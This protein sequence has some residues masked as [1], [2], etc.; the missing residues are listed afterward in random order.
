MR[1]L[2]SQSFHTRASFTSE[3]T[4]LLVTSQAILS[5]LPAGN[6]SELPRLPTLLSSPGAVGPNSML[7]SLLPWSSEACLCA[8]LL[9]LMLLPKGL[10]SCSP[11]AQCFVPHFPPPDDWLLE[12][13]EKQTQRE[14]RQ[15]R[16]S[17]QQYS[18]S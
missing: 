7:V 9:T 15:D 5:C 10:V 6:L 1:S 3:N 4:Q 18:P 12:G 17:P 16:L 2:V 11:P 13:S 14:L 8:A